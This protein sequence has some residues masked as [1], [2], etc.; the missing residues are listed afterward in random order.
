ML[1]D[2][3]HQRCVHSPS[4]SYS[5]VGLFLWTREIEEVTVIDAV[6]DKW[7]RSSVTED[8]N[9]GSTKAESSCLELLIVAR[10]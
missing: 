5:I 4:S 3:C 1:L 7:I 6:Q 9:C 2:K 10:N 8:R